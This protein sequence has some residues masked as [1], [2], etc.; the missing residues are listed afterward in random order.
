VDPAHPSFFVMAGIGA[1]VAGV[2]GLFV[3]VRVG[4]KRGRPAPGFAVLGVVG[5]LVGAGL[6]AFPF[7]RPD[8]GAPGEPGSSAWTHK[9][10]P[11][12]FELT[13]PSDRWKKAAGG[14]GGVAF[15]SRL[16]QMVAVV[17]E[18]RPASAAAGFEMAVGD[19]K[20]VV[21][22]NSVI[23]EKRGPNAHGHEYWLFLGEEKNPKGRVFVAVSV[24][25]WNKS[26]AAVIL[27]EGQH[28]MM[29]QA[30]QAEEAAAFHEAARLVLGSVK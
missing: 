13:L 12:G 17:K 11:P 26:H 15:A 29:S 16:P 27:F 30:G 24:T 22:R 28:Q 14:K 5:V 1:I 25:W 8:G 4:R 21:A 9:V 7:L 3:A 6:I 19:L 18:V 23:E 2:V 20:R 10:D